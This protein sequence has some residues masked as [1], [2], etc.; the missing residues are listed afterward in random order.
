MATSDL[1][2]DENN[3]AFEIEIFS[4][5]EAVDQS[6]GT[7]SP[8]IATTSR[9]TAN[10]LEVTKIPAYLHHAG[11]SATTQRNLGGGRRRLDSSFPFP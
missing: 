4:R 8:L 5:P 9:Y 3:T 2:P 6:T 1:G 7:A 10:I 11:T